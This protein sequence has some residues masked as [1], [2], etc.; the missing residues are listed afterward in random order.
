MPGDSYTG[1]GLFGGLSF[2][3]L[4]LC[5]RRAARVKRSYAPEVRG[6]ATG[7]ARGIEGETAGSDFVVAFAGRHFASMRRSAGTRYQGRSGG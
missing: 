2:N 1:L 5:H 3:R 6:V 7:S 4:N